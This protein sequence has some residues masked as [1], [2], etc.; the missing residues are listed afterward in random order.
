MT[1]GHDD[2]DAEETG[3]RA[4]LRA[5]SG[6]IVGGVGLIAWGALLWFTFGDV[7]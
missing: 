6:V 1:Y 3:L 7:L 2:D 5:R 4:V